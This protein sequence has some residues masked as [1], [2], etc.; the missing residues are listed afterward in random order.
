L[1]CGGGQAAV[2]PL[3]GRIALVCT[4]VEQFSWNVSDG[5]SERCV[6]SAHRGALVCFLLLIFL[7]LLSFDRFVQL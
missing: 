4:F 3:C 1:C 6:A 7:R 5:T 2:L